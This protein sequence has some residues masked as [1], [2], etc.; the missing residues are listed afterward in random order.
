[1]RA[2]RVRRQLWRVRRNLP[3]A[4]AQP[5]SAVLPPFSAPEKPILLIGCPRSGTSVLL[6]ALLAGGELKSVQS[7][8]HILWD[9]YHH[10]R[11]RDW[12]SDS[13]GSADV[14][15]R[16]REYI[17]AAV[18][19][20]VGNR[21]FVDKTP[22]NCL[23]IPYLNTLFPDATFVFLHRRAADNVN[24]LMEAWRARPRF[25]RHRLP[26]P[27]QGIGPL[28]GNLWNFVLVPGWRDLRTAPLEEICAQQY[29]ACNEAALA[30]REKLSPDRWVE[31]A[32]E[33][34][35]D[36]PVDLVGAL[37]ERLGLGLNRA[38]QRRVTE[39][40]ERPGP[41]ALTAPEPDKWRRQ[42]EASVERIL[43][44]VEPVE[45]ELYG[46]QPPDSRA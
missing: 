36:S 38:T 30:A 42:N 37:Y 31:C 34:L 12:E 40:L 29:V 21:R 19:L 32:Y 41:T 27:L 4:V 8:G 39:V 9:A 20:V 43:P 7:E 25:V 44:L 13:L 11:N 6:R 35:V 5:L 15:E 17:Y 3:R 14:V 23:R 46:P 16:E 24:S 1:M 26:E 10:P 45:S 22:E 2:F 18:R 28:D 33:D